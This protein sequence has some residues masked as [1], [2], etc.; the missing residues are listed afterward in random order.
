M[1]A[2]VV[3]SHPVDD[4]FS[5]AAAARA[6]AGLRQAGH[7]VDVIDLYDEGFRA[8]MTCAELIAYD[9]GSPILDPQVAEHAARLR[10]AEIV[11]FVY[12]TWWSGLPAMLKGWL[13]RVMVPGVAFR[14]EGEPAKVRPALTHVRRIVGITSY[15]ST[16]PIIRLLAD[17]GRRTITRAFRLACG[18]RTRTTWLGLYGMDV[19]DDATRRQHLD[20]VERTMSRVR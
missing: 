11:V 18:F 1:N 12:P 20:K 2:L 3:V 5:H 9:T 8:T 7:Q 4:S 17:S 10:R 14:L 15:G 13:D 6:V 16:Q 19:N